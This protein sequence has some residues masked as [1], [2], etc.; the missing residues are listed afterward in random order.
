MTK[1]A[2]VVTENREEGVLKAIE[3]LDINPV[4]GK[5]VIFKPNFNTADPPPASTDLGALKVFL[6]KLQEMG[7]KSITVAERSGPVDTN[8]AFI[9]RVQPI[10]E[11]LGVKLVNLAEVPIEEYVHVTPKD[12]HWKNGFLFSK[13]YYEAECIVEFGCIKTHQYGG[14]FTLSLK[15]ATGLVPRRNLD[16][17]SYMRELH[18]SP[19][20]R[21]LIAEINT[22]FSP[23]LIVMD[24]VDIF[25]DG[26]P[27]K[28]TVKHAKVVIA[29]TDRIA[30]DAVGVAIL[31][32]Q[33]TTPEVS[34][35]RIFEQEQIKRAVELNLGINDPSEID[36]L[37]DSQEADE[38][39]TRI[40]NE[41]LT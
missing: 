34:Q 38:L 16:G 13:L 2:I 36:F 11:E 41:L 7:A 35:G 39:S 37:T 14:H 8:E 30:I 33:G 26:G 20:Q 23:D 29:G 17:N 9:K 22:Q 32:I 10:A 6:K 40:L 25:V 28:G 15:L 31:R 3:L 18:S 27:D 4:K 21:K 12:S 19:H 5:D 24:G 1:V